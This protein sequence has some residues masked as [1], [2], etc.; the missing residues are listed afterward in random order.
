M[1]EPRPWPRHALWARADC[2][3]W[4]KEIDRLGEEAKVALENNNVYKARVAVAEMQRLAVKI[5][6]A[7][8]AVKEPPGDN[9]R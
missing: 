2:I 9:E 3:A 7:L 6:A 4:A 5:V 1:T 8:L